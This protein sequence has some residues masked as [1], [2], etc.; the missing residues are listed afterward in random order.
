[1]IRLLVIMAYGI[2]PDFGNMVGDE[3]VTD[4]R[5]RRQ[6]WSC[7]LVSGPAVRAARLAS[8]QMSDA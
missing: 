3:A 5:A 4:C 6:M 7:S 2:E 1:M 8:W